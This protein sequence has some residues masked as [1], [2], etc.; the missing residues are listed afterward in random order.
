MPDIAPPTER[1]P[2]AASAEMDAWVLRVLGVAVARGTPP[3]DT[4]LRDAVRD[5]LQTLS[6]DLKLLAGATGVEAAR[7]LF[8]AGVTAAKAKDYQGALEAL[9]ACS[10]EVA[11]LRRAASAADAKGSAEPGTVHKAVRDFELAEAAWAAGRLRAIDGMNALRQELDA[12]DDPELHEISARIG[13]LIDGMSPALEAA[14]SGLRQT[15]AD[16][17]DAAAARG[18]VEGLLREAAA[19]L[20]A[21]ATDLQSCEENPWNIAIAIRAPLAAALQQIQVALK[22]I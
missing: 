4:S 15:L 2:A 3:D 10:D 5:M 13:L 16:A 14:I 12:S 8:D 1:D 11:K 9:G 17:G 6:A 22:A 7:S 20:A 19:F 21:N 18:Q